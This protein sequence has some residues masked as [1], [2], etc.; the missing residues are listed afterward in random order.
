MYD[1]G[2]KAQ[3]HSGKLL[4]LTV[5]NILSTLTYLECLHSGSNSNTKYLTY[6]LSPCDLSSAFYFLC[7][8]EYTCSSTTTSVTSRIV[9]ILS[10][11]NNLQFT[12]ISKSLRDMFYWTTHSYSHTLTRR[13]IL[14][15]LTLIHYSSEPFIVLHRQL[16]ID[17][18]SRLKPRS[19]PHLLHIYAS[20]A[21]SRPRRPPRGS[22]RRPRLTRRQSMHFCKPI[23]TPSTCMIPRHETESG[24][25]MSLHCLCIDSAG[26]LDQV[27]RGCM[28]DSA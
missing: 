20:S 10:L 6:S 15:R 26:A 21:Y 24:Y 17:H 2:L 23:D 22:H 12:G 5:L 16:N 8:V 27:R 19:T 18:I 14:A 4:R 3:K 11:A 1:W 13:S 7:Q 25:S 9:L 28:V